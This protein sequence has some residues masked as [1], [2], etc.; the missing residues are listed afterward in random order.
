MLNNRI[1]IDGSHVVIGVIV[2]T[3]WWLS[4]RKNIEFSRTELFNVAVALCAISA[5]VVLYL[6][7]NASAEFFSRMM[8]KHNPNTSWDLES[9]G[10]IDGWQR[11]AKWSEGISSN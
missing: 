11:K 8:W 1:N 4:G 7:H 3:A 5:V 2:L 9:V 6:N 10:K